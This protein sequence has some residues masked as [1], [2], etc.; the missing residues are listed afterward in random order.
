MDKLE[1]DFKRHHHF[2]ISPLLSNQRSMSIRTKKHSN[3]A[4][5]HCD[6][7]GGKKNEEPFLFFGAF[8]RTF[9]QIGHNFFGF[10]SEVEQGRVGVVQK[11]DDH[12]F[13]L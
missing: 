13:N 10:K 12:L 1:A 8:H 4:K 7:V 6:T 5:F 9:Q 11:Y 2:H 3:R